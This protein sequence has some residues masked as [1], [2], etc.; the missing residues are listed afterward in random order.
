[1]DN[2]VQRYKEFGDFL[3]TR[4]AKILPSQVGLPEGTRAEH[5]VLEE[6]TSPHFLA[7]V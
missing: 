3:K 5:Q 2:S 6:K 1:M 4:R 7:S